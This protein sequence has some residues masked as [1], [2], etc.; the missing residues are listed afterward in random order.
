[1]LLTQFSKLLREGSQYYKAIEIV[2]KTGGPKKKRTSPCSASIKANQR[3]CKDSVPEKPQTSK[4]VNESLKHS[5]LL[6]YNATKIMQV[7]N[8]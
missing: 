6:N 1:M 7:K 8:I 4:N 2:W 3:K 5:Q